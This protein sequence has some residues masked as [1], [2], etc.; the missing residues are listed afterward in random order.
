M[1]DCPG[2]PQRRYTKGPRRHLAI[3]DSVGKVEALPAQVAQSVEQR[4]RNA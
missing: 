4:T 1:E 2:Q 3:A